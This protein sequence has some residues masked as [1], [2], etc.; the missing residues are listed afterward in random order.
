MTIYIIINKTVD[1]TLADMYIRTRD[2]QRTHY[3]YNNYYEI[4][5]GCWCGWSDG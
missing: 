5:E 4:G 1:M 3:N 2:Q